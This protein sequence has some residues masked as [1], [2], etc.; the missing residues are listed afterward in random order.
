MKNGKLVLI[1]HT[2]IPYV[3]NH[4]NWPHG[5]D[6][7][8]E[9]VVECYVPLLNVVDDLLNEGIKANLTIDI[10]PVVCEQMTQKGFTDKFIKYCKAKIQC[11]KDDHKNF[12][13]WGY[14]PH[15]IYL[16]KW[17]E[18]WY[19][20]R[21]NDYLKK[22]DG[23]II[24]A[25]KK[26][27]DL[28]AIEMMTCGATH[29]YFPLLPSEESINLQIKLAVENYK[30]HFGKQPNGIW[31]PECA[32]RPSYDWHSYLPIE[33]F[34]QPRLRPGIEQ[35]LAKH[36][37]EYFVSDQLLVENSELL[38]W[39][40]D[41]EQKYF[42]SKQD[43]FSYSFDKT[44]LQVYNV[45]SSDRTEFGTAKVFTRH[46]NL[47]M[48]VWSAEA[49][50]PGEPDYLDFHKKQERSMLR[51]WRVT[52]VKTD[53]GDKLL[54][55]PDS[56]AN[57]VD[58]QAHDFIHNVENTVNYHKNTTGNDAVVSLP[59]DTELFG[60]WWFEGP[61]F[62]KA[63][64]KG[65]NDS[66]YLDI[67]QASDLCDNNKVRSVIRLSEGSWGKN[68][69]HDVWYNKENEWTWTKLYDAE[70]RLKSIMPR[71]DQSDETTKPL[72]K[73]LFRELL[74]AQSS[75]W[76]FLIT[77]WAARDYAEIRFHN[78][79]SDL[80]KLLDI[81]EKYLETKKLSKFDTNFLAELSTR[82]NIFEEIDPAWW[83]D[84]TFF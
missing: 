21:L 73:Q 42:I 40:A 28:G 54:Y 44:P 59:F 45:S 26:Y 15:H 50:Y 58:L 5:E 72:L 30:K 64:I 74:L 11:A 10:S 78:H 70:N 57:K 65:L 31:L 51:Y 14:D 38:G 24:S 1:L 75:D 56:I 67:H 71:I 35:F 34:N 23:N 81:C 63:L 39:F 68:N 52:D 84:L 46:T 76:Q 25:L 49:G 60:H 55:Y 7:L 2:H 13:D 9:A 37:I 32:Y 82:N 62:I 8:F 19:S 69:N 43:V 77:T 20:D 22:Y 48:K 16:S 83:Q 6:W 66:P 12:T 36:N 4:G 53:M 18:E 3:M 47:S 27:Q 80:N 41:V 33:P 29:G 17:W 79:I 61:E